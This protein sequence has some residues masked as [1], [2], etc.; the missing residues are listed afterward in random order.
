M[1]SRDA[2][3]LRCAAL[4][5]L[6]LGIGCTSGEPTSRST[7]GTS[8]SQTATAG[9]DGI[10]GSRAAGGSAGS[11]TSTG[12]GGSAVA[13]AGDSTAG[14]AGDGPAGRTG[15][16]GA[17]NGGAGQGGASVGG[18]GSAGGAGAGGGRAGAGGA[19]AVDHDATLSIMRR[20]ADYELARFAPTP[21]DRNWARAVFYTGLMAFYSASGDAKYLKAAQSWGQTNNWAL[22]TDTN[23][24]PL[25]PP[26]NSRFADNQ[27]CVQT[28]AELY[29]QSPTP[30][31][32]APAATAFDRMLSKEVSGRTEWWWCDSLFMAPAALGRAAKALNKPEYLALMHRLYWDTKAYLYSP[33]QHLFYRDDTFLASNTFW[34]RGNG[35]VFAGLARIVEV[36]PA[37][38]PRRS[39]YEALLRDMAE[40]LRTLQQSDGFWRS[41]LLNPN[42]YSMRESSGTAFYCFGLSWGINNGVLDRATYLEPAKRAW[43]AL[44]TVVSTAGRLGWVQGV[45]SSPGP[46]TADN[47]NDYATG[48]FLLCGNEMLKL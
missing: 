19:P 3:V 33:A 29:L 15:T 28:Y 27:A 20:V 23:G 47:T 32:L 13:G 26:D 22:G 42:A 35:W 41:D 31:M 18:G 17:A 48:A 7:G 36:L 24:R 38:D 45:G 1:V 10:A 16:G 11:V 21:S 30:A 2:K 4:A 46:S 6:G 5:V 39:D 37:D 43:T 44:T 34:S 9:N 25:S 14:A 12:G 8:G 40:K